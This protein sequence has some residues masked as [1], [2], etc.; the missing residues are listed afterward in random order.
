MFGNGMGG[1]DDF[2]RTSGVDHG[3]T[4]NC[5]NNSHVFQRLMGC[6]EIGIGHS[7]TAANDLDILPHIA[8]IITEH[9]KRP[10]GNKRGNRYKE[11]NFPGGSQARTY[12]YDTLLHNPELKMTLGEFLLKWTHPRSA[13]AVR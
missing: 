5:S 1:F 9:F 12:S 11:R 10:G 3:D 8:K 6:T 13:R 7:G 2:Y 4:G